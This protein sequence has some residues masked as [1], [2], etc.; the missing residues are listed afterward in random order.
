M[1]YLGSIGPWQIILILIVL[2]LGI[3]LP[4]IA[5]IDIVRSEFKS[6]DKLIWVLIV[7]F[8]NVLGSILYLTIGKNQKIS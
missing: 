5:F 4:L 8:F 7:V 6:N 3:I 2:C 1:T